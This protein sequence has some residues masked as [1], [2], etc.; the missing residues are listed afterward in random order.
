MG[1]GGKTTNESTD[2]RVPRKNSIEVGTKS[3]SVI[4]RKYVILLNNLIHVAINI[5]EEEAWK[6]MGGWIEW[7]VATG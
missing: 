6:R 5:R 1:S 7:V 4:R 3:M 2:Y